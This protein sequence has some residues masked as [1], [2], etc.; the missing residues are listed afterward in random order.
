MNRNQL[1][2]DLRSMG[3][4]VSNAP[5]DSPKNYGITA[6]LN[7][8]VRDIASCIKATAEAGGFSVVYGLTCSIE[9]QEDPA[10]DEADWEQ[11]VVVWCQLQTRL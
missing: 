6:D 1:V 3:L 10:V 7:T 5:G 11:F 4:V 8:S 2:R 9:S